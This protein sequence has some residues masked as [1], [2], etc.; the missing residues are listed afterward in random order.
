MIEVMIAMMIAIVVVGALAVMFVTANDS[1][2]A[3]Q[4]QVSLLSLAQQQIERVR[5]VVKGSGFGAL[6]LT[7]NPPAGADSP[8]PSS[9]ADPNDFITS[10][11]S[12]SEA[13]LIETNYNS[14]A[15]GLAANTPSAGEP[16]LVNGTNG[17]SGGQLTPVVYVDI[18]NGQTYSS[19][20]SVPAGD[21]FGS[22]HTYVT[23]SS[24][25]GCNAEINDTDGDASAGPDG[26]GDDT[27]CAGD[28]RRVI[29]A[30]RLN[31][32]GSAQGLGSNTPTY[33]TTVFVNPVPSNQPN[34]ASGLRLLG[35]IP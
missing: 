28:V 4:R 13:F 29:V 34:S 20:A 7:S 18:A 23:Q 27:S 33:T 24:T 22:V 10:W 30:V 16:L 25:A 15:E 1:S 8:L 6:A 12:G 11:G 17:I 26:D 2:I 9:P 19:A 31:S 32:V 3:N 14:T 5:D 35:L 21:S